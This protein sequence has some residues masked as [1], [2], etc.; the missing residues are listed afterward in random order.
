[1]SYVDKLVEE[2][3]EGD[4]SRIAELFHDDTIFSELI[5][6]GKD[7]DWYH[8]EPKT[9]DGEYFVKVGSGYACYEQ[10]RGSKSHSMSFGNIHEA[11]IHYFTRAGYIKPPQDKKWWQFWA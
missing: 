9:Y 10:E 3:L 6:R 2:K 5:A 11:A 1:M 4:E 7:S 8:F